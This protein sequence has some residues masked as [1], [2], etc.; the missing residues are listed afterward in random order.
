MGSDDRS[1]TVPQR[2]SSAKLAPVQNAERKTLFP[3]KT[4]PDENVRM[5]MLLWGQAN[6]GKTT[7]AATAPGNKLWLSFGDN[8]H[9]PVAAR[10]DVYRIELF[11]LSPDEIFKHGVGSNPFG[12]RQIITEHNIK[13]IV[14]DSLTAVQDLALSKAVA[15]KIGESNKFVPTMAQPGRSAFGGRNQFLLEIM[16]AVAGVAAVMGCHVIFTSHENDPQTKTEG[17][18]ETIDLISMSLGGQLVNKVSHRISEIW[19]FRQEQGGQRNRIITTRISAKRRPMKTRMFDQHGSASFV[20]NYNPDK[21]DS[22]P[23]QMTIAGFHEQW[24]KSG[25]RR[26]PVPDNRRGGDD[27]DN[28]DIPIKGST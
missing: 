25:L 26:I 11:G 27:K 10:K 13:T 22:A 2:E 5:V 14:C 12:I 20:L 17:G 19:N 6:V 15:D 7:W 8:E 9:V 28:L 16:R 21:P 24:V 3:P 23:G 18:V 4:G 1:R